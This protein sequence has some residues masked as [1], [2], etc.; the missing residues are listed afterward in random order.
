[1]W[2]SCTPVRV[3]KGTN[4][5]TDGIQKLAAHSPHVKGIRYRQSAD[6]TG[7]PRRCTNDAT[8]GRSVFNQV[9]KLGDIVGLIA[10]SAKAAGKGAKVAHFLLQ[11]DGAPPAHAGTFARHTRSSTSDLLMQRSSSRAGPGLAATGTFRSLWYLSCTSFATHQ[12]A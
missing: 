12:P 3:R 8:E 11:K 2:S 10:T 5:L 6:A 4:P 7:H 1:M 9:V